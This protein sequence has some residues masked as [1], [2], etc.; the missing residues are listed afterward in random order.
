MRSASSAASSTSRRRGTPTCPASAAPVT[1]PTSTAGTAPPFARV[2][3]ASADRF[4]RRR[5]R[6]RLVRV[7]A[8][9]FYLSFGGD[10]SLPGLGAVQDE[11]VV[12]YNGGTWSVY[13]DGTAHGLDAPATS[14]WMPSM[15]PK[16][17]HSQHGMGIA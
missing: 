13:F 7:D 9:H 6:R 1:M 17:D 10:T 14:T 11:D 15:C 12:Y 16:P 2:C 4:G 8:T 3:D 5:E